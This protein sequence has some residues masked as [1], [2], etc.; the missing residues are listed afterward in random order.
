MMSNIRCPSCGS[1]EK[2]TLIGL[3][4]GDYGANF[5]CYGCNAYGLNF[6][7]DSLEEQKEEALSEAE[8]A[9]TASKALAK[10]FHESRHDWFLV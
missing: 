3:P 1:A 2:V 8:E 6:S 5:R 4:A 7:S 9:R 10:N